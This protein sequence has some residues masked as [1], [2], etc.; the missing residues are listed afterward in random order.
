MDTVFKIAGIGEILWD[1]LPT[2]KQLGGAPCNFAYHCRQA[3][4][5]GVVVSAVGNDRL[6]GE[7][8]D[9]LSE[10]GVPDSY[11]QVSNCFGTG[12]VNVEVDSSGVPSYDIKD[13]VAWDNIA[14]T[15]SLS[16]L[17]SSL[18]AVCFGSLAQRNTVSRD[19]IM[20]FV[21]STRR[22]CLRVFDVNLRQSYFSPEVIVKSLELANVL[23]L[24]DEEL[25]V[26]AGILGYS[27][28][29]AIASLMRDFGI[30]T[31]AYTR[32]ANGSILFR[33]GEMSESGASDTVVEDTV[34]AGDSFT[35]MLVCG[36][37]KG[38]D[39]Y[40]LHMIAN[41]VASFVCSRKG[42]TPAIPEE[43]LH[44]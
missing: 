34:G 37:L 16:S 2:G 41:K 35:A 17:A 19:T 31:V 23:K 1:V 15:P 11:V 33:G 20:S 18:D 29:R 13:G 44:K 6:G 40:T 38:L 43:L 4:A 10:L 24:N 8:L 14:F 12:V 7:L 27:E 5:D 22:D 21:S 25:P 28:E 30:G 3:G 36:I 32:G 39:L 9:R 26:I 42:A